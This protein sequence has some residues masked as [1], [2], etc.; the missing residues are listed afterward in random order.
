[1]LKALLYKT[2]SPLV[3]ASPLTPN[4]LDKLMAEDTGAIYTFANNTGLTMF[5]CLLACVVFIWGL[6]A[7]YRI[8]RPKIEYL[9]DLKTK[10]KSI[11]QD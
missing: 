1:M 3:G 6:V 4:T 2:L 9:D 7:C 5:W 10:F 8:Y 11:P